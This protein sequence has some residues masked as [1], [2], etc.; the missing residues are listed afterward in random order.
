[1]SES[2]YIVRAKADEDLDEQAFYYATE[3]NPELGHRFLLSAHNTFALLATEPQMGWN[4][5]LRH[6]DLRALRMFRV[7]GFETTLILYRPLEDGI[8]VLRVVHGSRNI[9][10]L[11]HREGI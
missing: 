8:E 3:A 1:V 2:R 11:L 10:R 4:P 6:R 5:R 9:Q 7:T